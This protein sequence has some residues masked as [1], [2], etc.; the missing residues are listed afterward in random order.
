LLSAESLADP[1]Y[2]PFLFPVT[3]ISIPPSIDTV[4]RAVNVSNISIAISSIYSTCFRFRFR[5][6]R[7]RK[8]SWVVQSLARLTTSQSP[9]RL[10]S[11]GPTFCKG[12]DAV[13]IWGD[14]HMQLTV[15]L[16]KWGYDLWV[17]KVCGLPLIWW[18]MNLWMR[19]MLVSP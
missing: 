7:T 16:G 17:F 14:V 18:E 10:W 15:A 19:L 5:G 13:V 6:L 11:T 1:R 8:I 3:C 9:C 4:D 2:V 12:I